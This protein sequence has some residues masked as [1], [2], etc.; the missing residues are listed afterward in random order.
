MHLI[1]SAHRY[2]VTESA[3]YF[4]LS[5]HASLAVVSENHVVLLGV[6]Q[7]DLPWPCQQR[8]ENL[9]GIT[10]V[11]KREPLLHEKGTP[12]SCRM[13]PQ[14]AEHIAA[15]ASQMA[16]WSHC[17]RRPHPTLQSFIKAPRRFPLPWLH[18]PQDLLIANLFKTNKQASKQKNPWTPK[19]NKNN[20]P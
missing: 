18:W 6:E 7:G 1:S 4:R 17:W 14:M 13:D 11:T 20:H 12:Q 8:A 10:A 3:L 15:V 19:A 16:V 9:W 2:L 5:F